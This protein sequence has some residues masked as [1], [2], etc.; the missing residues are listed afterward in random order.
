MEEF[1]TAPPVARRLAPV[2]A[3]VLLG[4]IGLIYAVHEHHTAQAASAENQQESA[5]LAA[6]RTQLNALTAKVNEMTAQQAAAQQAAQPAPVTEPV[7]TSAVHRSSKPHAGHSASDKRFAK[8]Q[9]QLDEQ[10]REIEATRG[11]LSD[12]RTTLTGSIAHT[13]DELVV[14]ERKGERS[15]FEFDLAKDKQFKH[16]GPVG[17]SLRKANVKHQ[18]ADL[19]LMVDDRN[20]AQKHV[21]LDQPVMF[22]MPD[23][24]QPVQIVIND[25]TKD[26]IHGYVSAPSYRKSELTAM[27]NTSASPDHASAGVAQPAPRKRLTVAQQ[28][29]TAQDGPQ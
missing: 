27:A 11:D 7:A 15:Y 1:E 26:H 22:F 29:G 21:N 13:H 10:N 24:E 17:I 28:D 14:L 23:T 25:I 12:T 16:E 4:G 9:A 3:A 2:L 20:L 19:A 5:D 18:Y 6:A 8:M